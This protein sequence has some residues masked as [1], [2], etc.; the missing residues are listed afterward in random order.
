MEWYWN[1]LYYTYYIGGPGMAASL[2]LLLLLLLCLKTYQTIPMVL[3]L[4]CRSHR[5]RGAQFVY[6]HLKTNGI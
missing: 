3:I 5:G 2:L 4:K 6:N 1:F